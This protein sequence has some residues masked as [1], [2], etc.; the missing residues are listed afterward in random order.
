MRVRLFRPRL[1]LTLSALLV[2]GC[3]TVYEGKLDPTL[4][5]RS[6][7]S[8]GTKLNGQVVL[9]ADVALTQFKYERAKGLQKLVIPVGPIVEAA[10]V[11]ALSDEFG[12]SVAQYPSPEAAIDANRSVT[13]LTLVVP[14]PVQF[15]H[16]DEY[17]PLI[18]PWFVIPI[19]V[20]QDVRLIVD[21]QVLDA[22][23]K[24]RWTKRYDSGDVKLPFNRT[25]DRDIKPEHYFAHLAHEAA[26]TLMRQAAQDVRDWIES[27]RLRERVL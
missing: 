7:A 20:R 11:A 19:N 10:A 6:P 8:V 26:Y 16:H 18:T 25:D 9:I 4:F 5:L 17:L 24:L 15:E 1:L 21:W 22:N 27:E 13:Q 2:A 3:A 12:R 14:R 23:G